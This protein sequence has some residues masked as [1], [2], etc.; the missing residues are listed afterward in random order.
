MKFLNI[1]LIQNDVLCRTEA[2]QLQTGKSGEIIG[3]LVLIC[4][5]LGVDIP[6]W[7]YRN[8][9]TLSRKKEVTLQLDDTLQM[10]VSMIEKSISVPS[11][12]S[13]AGHTIGGAKE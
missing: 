1:D 11:E 10:R 5:K 9:R 7:T 13:T 12:V 2:Q 3:A 4:N 8:E 6:V